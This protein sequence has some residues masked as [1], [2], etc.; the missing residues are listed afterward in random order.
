MYVI[1]VVVIVLS[2]VEHFLA[3]ATGIV[4]WRYLFQPLTI[5][6][7]RFQVMWTTSMV[8]ACS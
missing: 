3:N 1:D 4:V 7:E 2:F 8:V 6:V 5:V